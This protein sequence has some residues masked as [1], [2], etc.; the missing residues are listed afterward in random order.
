MS[1]SQSTVNY[2]RLKDVPGYPT[3]DGYAVGS[4]GSVWTCL[5]RLPVLGSR[6]HVF[7]P[8]ENNWRPL[9]PDCLRSGHKQ[10]TL[11]PDRRRVLVHRLVLETFVGPCPEGM[12]CCHIDG[13]ASNNWLHNLR[14]DTRKANAG[15]RIKHGTQ[16]RG[17]IMWAAKLTAPLVLAMR[18]DRAAG[19]SYPK[20][21]KKYRISLSQVH[22]IVTRQSW[23]HVS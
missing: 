4:D 15:D 23:A 19:L 22:R 3:C 6:G 13:D 14:W 7:Q 8:D 10:V 16:T 11:Q 5:R 9:K 12:E 1:V 18:S 21:V 17:E 2:R 20:L